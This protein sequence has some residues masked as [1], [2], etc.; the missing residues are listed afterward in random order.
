MEIEHLL[1]VML[2]NHFSSIRLNEELFIYTDQKNLTFATLNYHHVHH[3][4]S[5]M[6]DYDSTI[7]Y[8]HGKKI[9]IANTFL[10]LPQCVVIPFPGGENVPVL[11]FYFTKSGLDFSNN[12]SGKPNTRQTVDDCHCNHY[13]QTEIPCKGP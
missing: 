1:T 13:Q 12:N 8:H 5:F 7:L 6:E 11:L 4:W 10:H 3:W 2:I 9:V